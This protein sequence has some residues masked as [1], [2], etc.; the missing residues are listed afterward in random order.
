[1]WGPFATLGGLETRY[2]AN[3]AFTNSALL[4]LDTVVA[5]SRKKVHVRLDT[6]FPVLSDVAQLA[7]HQ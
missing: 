2:S 4:A 3:E 7:H 6:T 5:G 1:M